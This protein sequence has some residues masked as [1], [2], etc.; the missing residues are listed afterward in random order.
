MSSSFDLEALKEDLRDSPQH[1]LFSN[2][3]NV[4]YVADADTF[5][6]SD[7]GN[8]LPTHKEVLTIIDAL[9]SYCEAV[10]SELIEDHNNA[11]YNKHRLDFSPSEEKGFTPMKERKLLKGFVYLIRYG[12]SNFYKIGMSK[13]PL[14]RIKQ[15]QSAIPEVLTLLRSIETLDMTA[16]EAY[17]H[18]MFSRNRVRSEWFEM[19]NSDISLFMD[20]TESGL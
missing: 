7:Q 15:I 13:K 1:C 5:L 16:L 4:K 9:C 14:E 8:F 2:I 6:F 11:I 3:W 12:N 19:T 10:P 17:F 20:Y 18:E